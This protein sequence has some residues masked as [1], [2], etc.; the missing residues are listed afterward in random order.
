MMV[1]QATAFAPNYNKAVVA[2]A[3]IFKLLDRIPLIDDNE[4]FGLRPVKGENFI[5]FI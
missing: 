4:H 1:G 2:A 3:R 5:Y